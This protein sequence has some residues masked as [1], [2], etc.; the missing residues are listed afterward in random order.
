MTERLVEKRPTY[1]RECATCP[2]A[3]R[4]TE[5]A[6]QILLKDEGEGQLES[7][8]ITIKCEGGN[9]SQGILGVSAEIRG[10]VKNGGSFV[11]T[12]GI[13][14]FECPGILAERSS[15]N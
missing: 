6:R 9:Y 10:R 5:R 15:K 13:G 4:A 12:S 8:E 11:S 14:N 3:N 7:A 2:H 1:Y